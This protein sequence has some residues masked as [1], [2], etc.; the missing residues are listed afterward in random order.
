MVFFSNGNDLVRNGTAPHECARWLEKSAAQYR[1]EINVVVRLHPNEDGSLY[2]NCP[3]LHVT[4][5]ELDLATTLNG[6]DWV[7]SICS[8]VLYDALLFKKNVWQ[9]QAEHW[10]QLANN[11]RQG[12]AIKISSQ[13]ELGHCMSEILSGGTTS[14][15]DQMTKRVFA[16]QGHS[17]EAVA[18]FVQ[19]LL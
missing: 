15:D 8:T 13:A 1:N 14:F 19:G 6:C 7:G 12:L 18:D 2:K 16:N 11:W 10:P 9:F 3:H 4:K 5:N 17:A